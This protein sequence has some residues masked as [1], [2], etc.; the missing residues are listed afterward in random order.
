MPSAFILKKIPQISQNFL[1]G[2][3]EAGIQETSP[4]NKF[5]AVLQTSTFYSRGGVW[6]CLDPL[7]GGLTTAESN[8]ITAKLYS[9]LQP[10][11]FPPSFSDQGHAELP[12]HTPGFFYPAGVPPAEAEADIAD[13]KWRQKKTQ[14]WPDG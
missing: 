4:Y 8:A 6:W 12:P 14:Q 5:S 10:I 1:S 11:S 7:G 2:Q 9:G 13:G 3:L